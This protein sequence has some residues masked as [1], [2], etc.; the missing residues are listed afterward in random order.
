MEIDE[1]DF[2]YKLI[3]KEVTSSW[4]RCLKENMNRYIVNSIRKENKINQFS[5]KT[6]VSFKKTYLKINQTIKT[7]HCLLLINK[8]K[9]IEELVGDIHF[10]NKLIK[11]NIDIGTSFSEKHIG[12]NAVYLAEKI[13]KPVYIL[14]GHH[15]CKPLNKWYSLAYPILKDNQIHGYVNLIN[16]VG[17]SEEITCLIDLL[18]NNLSLRLRSNYRDNNKESLEELSYN[19]KYILKKLANGFTE[20]ELAKDM[21]LSKSTIKYHKKV[22]FKYFKVSS[23]I[24]LVIKAIKIG[25]LSFKEV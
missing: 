19:Q 2:D 18:S 9:V 16:I 12:T 13:K 21:H 10:K 5:N 6:K 25:L 17:I 15:F 7:K 11:N 24:E 1:M 23:K 20:K 4:S 8:D 3:K 22:L 14:P